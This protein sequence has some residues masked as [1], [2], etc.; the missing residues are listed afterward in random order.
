MS[1]QGKQHVVPN[2]TCLATKPST[3]VCKIKKLLSHKLQQFVYLDQGFSLCISFE[4][5]HLLDEA[6]R[7]LFR[8]H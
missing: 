4:G 1:S 2:E 3:V 7:C 6:G 5:F 8:E